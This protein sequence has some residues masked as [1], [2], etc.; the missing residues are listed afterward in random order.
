M[1]FV[2]QSGERYFVA[3]EAE[4]S[5]PFKHPNRDLVQLVRTRS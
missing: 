3:V 2:A 5:K 1:V 4:G